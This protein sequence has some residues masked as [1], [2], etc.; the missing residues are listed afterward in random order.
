MWLADVR[1]VRCNRRL[2]TQS[3]RSS[4]WSMGKKPPAKR[5]SIPVDVRDVLANHLLGRWLKGVSWCRRKNSDNYEVVVWNAHGD[6]SVRSAW[7]KQV[8][9]IDFRD[10]YGSRLS[11]ADIAQSLSPQTISIPSYSTPRRE[12]PRRARICLGRAYRAVG[13]CCSQFLPGLL[14]FGKEKGTREKPHCFAP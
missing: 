5:T 12:N 9:R 13:H 7:E 1:V 2:S 6:L 4:C 14:D 8:G 11:A 10:G 3:A